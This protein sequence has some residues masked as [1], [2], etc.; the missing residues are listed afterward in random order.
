M[1]DDQVFVD[2]QEI[3]SNLREVSDRLADGEGTV[4]RLLSDDDGLY[5]NLNAAAEA[6]AEIATSIRDGEG[7]L[8]RL[9]SEDDL[10]VEIQALITEVRAAVDDFRE[11]APIT[12]FSSVFFGAF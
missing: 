3:T 11:T 4:G 6:I 2:L 12:S 10:Y 9:A 7:T 1:Q 5:E 8:G